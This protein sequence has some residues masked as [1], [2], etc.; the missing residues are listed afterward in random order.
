MVAFP[1]IFGIPG[2]L[3]MFLGGIL[4]N[5]FSPWGVLDVL[6][7]G[8]VSGGTGFFLVYYCGVIA[9]RQKREQPWLFIA[10]ISDPVIT[11]F[12]VAYLLLHRVYEIPLIPLIPYCFLEE[13]IV[14]TC[15]GYLVYKGVKRLLKGRGTCDLPDK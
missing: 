10:L 11:T 4:S 9:R 1:F 14:G 5:F 13:F 12:F 7:G 3:G 6:L 8:V 15:G 2:F